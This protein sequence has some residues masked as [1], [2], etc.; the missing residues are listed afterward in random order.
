M[1]K[2]CKICKEEKP[3]EDFPAG[4]G[5]KN[6]LRPYCKPC[7]KEYELKNYHKNKHKRPY[8]YLYDKDKKLKKAFGISYG[9]YQ[10]ML[11]VQSNACAICKTTNTG[12]RRAF[13]VDH[14]HTTGKI[15]GLLCSNC[16]TGIGNLRD[17]VELLKQ[18]IHY[19][20]NS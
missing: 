17:S 11:E 8:D 12:K 10:K 18:A 13:A 6:G 7:R 19:L 4:K 1:L 3:A 16:N 9:E 5:Y 15:R 2:I 14:C 20:E